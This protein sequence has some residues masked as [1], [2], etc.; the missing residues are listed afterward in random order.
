MNLKRA[1]GIVI[2][3]GAGAILPILL[4]FALFQN[5]AAQVAPST[6][7]IA[8][9]WLWLLIYCGSGIVLITRYFPRMGRSKFLA[10]IYFYDLALHASLLITLYALIYQQTGLLIGTTRITEPRDFL[11]FSIVSWTTLGYGDIIPTS[12]SRMF[13]ASEALFGY[14]FM[15][16]YLALVLHTISIYTSPTLNKPNE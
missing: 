13:A 14:V 9:S 16:L 8:L 1:L 5:K 6:D 3:Y 11:Y 4:L 15:G 10:A 12:D 7:K 2:K